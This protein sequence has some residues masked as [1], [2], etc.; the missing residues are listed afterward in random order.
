[1][2]KFE[3]LGMG[4]VPISMGALIGRNSEVGGA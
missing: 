1:M 3:K 4:K 2:K